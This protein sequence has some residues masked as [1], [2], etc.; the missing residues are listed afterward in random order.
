MR[1]RPVSV[2]TSLEFVAVMGV[3]VVLRL[4]TLRKIVVPIHARVLHASR[5]A[6][7]TQLVR[8]ALGVRRPMGSVRIKHSS[9]KPAAEIVSVTL[10]LA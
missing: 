1:R 3:V 5:H 8:A 10:A 6:Q 9:G 2:M 7:M 4:E